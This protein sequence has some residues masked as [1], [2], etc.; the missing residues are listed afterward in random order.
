MAHGGGESESD[1]TALSYRQWLKARIDHERYWFH[2]IEL[3]PGLVTPGWSDPVTDKLPYFGLPHDMRG[4]RVL[5]IGCSEGF[6]SFEAERRGADEVVAIDSMPDSV[7]RFNICRDAL[8]AKTDAYL[9]NV[10]DLSVRAYGTFDLVLFF[11]V[12]YHLRHPILALEKILAVCTG[13]MLLQTAI[14]EVPGMPDTP[15]ARFHP[16]RSPER[17]AGKPGLRSDGD[18]AAERGMHARHGGARGVSPDRDGVARAGH[19]PAGAGGG[20]R[21]RSRARP[22]HRA[23]VVIAMTEV[24]PDRFDARLMPGYHSNPRSPHDHENRPLAHLPFAIL[25]PRDVGGVS[26]ARCD[27]VARSTSPLQHERRKSVSAHGDSRGKPV[28]DVHAARSTADPCRR[29]SHV[30][31]PR[32]LDLRPARAERRRQDDDASDPDDAGASDVGTRARSW[33]TTWSK[34][35]SRSAKRIGVVIQEQAADLL[36]NVRDNLLTFARFHGLTAQRGARAP[37]T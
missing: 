29:R 33:D 21:A 7:R 32:G 34:R 9:C 28:Q 6:F 31:R 24:E 14:F 10:Y 3:A 30:L 20:E 23:V 17:P 37:T 19:R 8:G 4:M 1:G 22:R 36:L 16:S 11:G 18:L 35:R 13:T 5:D 2:R 15:L 12:L 26:V 27:Q 25:N